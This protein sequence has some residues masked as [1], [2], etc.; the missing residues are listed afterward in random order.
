MYD[1]TIG[2]WTTEDPIGFKAADADLF[3]YV[4]NNPTNLTDPTGLQQGMQQ[5]TQQPARPQPGTSEGINQANAQLLKQQQI[6]ALQMQIRMAKWDLERA[7]L[8]ANLAAI[9]IKAMQDAQRA[10]YDKIARLN[11][12]IDINNVNIAKLIALGQLDLA[13]EGV[14]ANAG[15]S[16]ELSRDESN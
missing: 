9:R 12:Q 11:A 4:G 3:R 7:Q 14:Q 1:P 2:R 13:H 16:E 5:G 6:A 15:L 8:A 10:I